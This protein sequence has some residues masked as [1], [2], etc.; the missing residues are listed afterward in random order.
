VSDK[1]A[2]HLVLA[3]Q[4]NWDILPTGDTDGYMSFD[5]STG[6]IGKVVDDLFSGQVIHEGQLWIGTCSKDYFEYVKEKDL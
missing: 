4:G 5:C 1:F 2:E 3:A 6:Y